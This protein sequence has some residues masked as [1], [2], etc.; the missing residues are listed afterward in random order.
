[1]GEG[2]AS[3]SV[4][5]RP[6]P[7]CLTPLLFKLGGNLSV[8]KLMAGEIE[9]KIATLY[10]ILCCFF[11]HSLILGGLW[12]WQGGGIWGKL[13][14]FTGKWV[15]NSQ[16]WGDAVAWQRHS[17]AAFL[18]PLFPL[19][20]ASPLPPLSYAGDW[21]QGGKATLQKPH[22]DGSRARSRSA[23]P[24]LL[25]GLL[26]HLLLLSK[27]EGRKGKRRLLLACRFFFP[28]GRFCIA[29]VWG[30]KAAKVIQ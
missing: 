5:V 22:S 3:E 16:L 19:L 1:M 17:C 23:L 26:H 2:L 13:A 15:C 14:Y 11:W 18:S 24:Y 21:S 6:L 28:P 9:E 30:H 12:V 4:P 10:L 8:K 29:L 7:H 25:G 20:E 27:L